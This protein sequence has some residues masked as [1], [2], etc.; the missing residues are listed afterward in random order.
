[1]NKIKEDNEFYTFLKESEKLDPIWENL[2]ESLK[3]RISELK[4]EIANENHRKT[5]LKTYGSFQLH[6]LK[7]DPKAELKEKEAKL[8]EVIRKRRSNKEAIKNI[9]ET[10]K[11]NAIVGCLTILTFAIIFLVIY[12]VA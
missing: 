12:L 2:E 9:E 4:I 8:E 11:K 10:N 3:R 6:S 7:P 1:M 5:V